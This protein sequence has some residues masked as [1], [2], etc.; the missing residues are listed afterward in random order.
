MNLNDRLPKQEVKFIFEK[1]SIVLWVEKTGNFEDIQKT[2]KEMF[3]INSSTQID[4]FAGKFYINEFLSKI[5][6]NKLC[7]VF[8]TNTFEVVLSSLN[9]LNIKDIT[10]ISPEIKKLNPK[11]IEIE[12]KNNLLSLENILEVEQSTRLSVFHVDKALK[13]LETKAKMMQLEDTNYENLNGLKLGEEDDEIRYLKDQLELEESKLQEMEE[14]LERNF[15]K[16]INYKNLEKEALRIF[17]ENRKIIG[18]IHNNNQL[19]DDIQDTNKKLEVK[20]KILIFNNFFSF[21]F[22]LNI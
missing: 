4:L 1:K 2:L 5:Q 11:K 3:K 18:S 15:E 8:F 13:E 14:D 21:L 12:C 9:L 7:E 17:K 10:I 19:R 22:Q 20:S 6:F 16:I